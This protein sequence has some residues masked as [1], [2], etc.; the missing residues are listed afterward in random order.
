MLSQGFTVV[1][2]RINFVLSEVWATVMSL[3]PNHW[4]IRSIPKTTKPAGR[5]FYSLPGCFE[6][7]L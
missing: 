2:I 6:V 3:L 1:A 7:H 5:R 4:R